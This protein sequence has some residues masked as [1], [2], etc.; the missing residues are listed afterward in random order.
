MTGETT[1]RAIE[2]SAKFMLTLI[3]RL[4]SNEELLERIKAEHREYRGL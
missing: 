2:D 1:H 3:I 4:Y